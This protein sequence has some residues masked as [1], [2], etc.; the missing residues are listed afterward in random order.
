VSSAFLVG[1]PAAPL[2]PPFSGQVALYAAVRLDGSQ[3]KSPDYSHCTFANVSFKEATISDGRFVDC[4]FVSCYFRRATLR[5]SSFQACKFIDC[6]FPRVQVESCDFRY[7]KFDKCYVSFGELEDSLPTEP[8]IREELTANL[9]READGLGAT[10]EAR[11]FR[12]RAIKAREQHLLNAVRSRSQWY[13]DHFPGVRRGAA[14]TSWMASKANGFIW[15]YGER[16][17]ALLRNLIVLAVIIFPLLFLA[18][19]TGLS[20]PRGEV[21]LG[22]CV[23]LS[24]SSILPAGDVSTVGAVDTLPRVLILLEVVSGYVIL[25]LFVTILLRAITRR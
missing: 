6:D 14:L 1:R 15:G 22:D 13:R 24:F 19:R 9:A 2:T 4:V 3:L 16:G 20:K 21:S 7:A 17:L 10:R 8:N 25:G 11:R 23:L 18:A 5:N 12:L